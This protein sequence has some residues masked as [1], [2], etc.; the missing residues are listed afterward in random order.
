M[1]SSEIMSALPIWSKATAEALL[2]S[3]AW[4]MPCRLG[5]T[6]AI[7]RKTD[8]RPIDTLDVVVLLED[9][10][11]ILSIADAPRFNDLHA[12][13]G[14]RADVLEPI[15]LALVE[16]NCGELL[17][18]V[19]NA[20]RHQLKIVEIGKG[21]FDSSGDAA[22]D[23]GRHPGHED[24]SVAGMESKPVHES[25][26]ESARRQDDGTLT[27]Q[28]DDIV[29]SITSSPALVSALGQLRFIDVSHPSVRAQ[30]LSF[31]TELAV[32]AMSAVD[33][34]SLAIGD[35]ILLPEVGTVPPRF[36]VDG[37]FLVDGN[38]V[39]PYVDDGRVRVIDAE[40]HSMTL[41]TLFDKAETP[42]TIEYSK[43]SQ[44]RLVQSGRTIAVGRLDHVG[45]QPAF[46]I[47][48]LS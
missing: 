19:E 8:I 43:P 21:T 45:D 17:Q 13:W 10:K 32:F 4:A 46:Q 42:Q 35:A 41:G 16:K 44:L 31:E 39:V 11:H 7:L 20:A 47:E 2:S 28:V 1:K 36:I 33:L 6:N 26:A 9:E 30:T 14:S 40:K 48:S 5:E 38:G 12:I 24:D 23:S 27:F 22:L 15:L 18:L 34:A 37:R 3:P 29:F 25:A